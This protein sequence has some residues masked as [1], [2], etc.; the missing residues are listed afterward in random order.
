[1]YSMSQKLWFCVSSHLRQT[2]L[3][4]SG[5]FS[6]GFFVLPSFAHAATLY[7]VGNDGANTSV[8]SNFAL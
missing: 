8:A 5:F 6:V 3:L 7:W 2:L 1:M 4:I